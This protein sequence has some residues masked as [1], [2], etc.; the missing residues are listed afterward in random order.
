MKELKL[1]E[2]KIKLSEDLEEL[3]SK[4]NEEAGD[5]GRFYEVEE[6]PD[7]EDLM[8]DFT[9]KTGRECEIYNFELIKVFHYCPT[10]YFFA[11]G[12]CRSKNSRDNWFKELNERLEEEEFPF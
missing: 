2:K 6:E 8:A 3:I 7:L 11:Y 9:K 4:A 5:I 10:E 1:E 12:D